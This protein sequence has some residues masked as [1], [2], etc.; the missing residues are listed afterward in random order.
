M[1]VALLASFACGG[2]HHAWVEVARDPNYTIYIDSANVTLRGRNIVD[3]VYRT[4]HAKPRLHNDETFSREVVRSVVNCASKRFKVAHVDMIRDD[5]RVVARQ[6]TDE[7]ELA[8]QRW[9]S[10]GATS[11]ERMAA[12]AACYFAGRQL[13]AER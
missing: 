6:W 9:R 10:I 8:A 11:A 13:A 7:N 3:V 2:G 4:D 1:A 12:E 5:G